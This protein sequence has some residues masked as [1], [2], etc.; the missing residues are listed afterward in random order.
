MTLLHIS[1][2]LYIICTV[3][4]SRHTCHYLWS[5]KTKVTLLYRN[6]INCDISDIVWLYIPGSLRA[7]WNYSL[8]IT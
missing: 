8:Y 7:T 2:R 5:Y 6:A 1:V 3:R 4:M